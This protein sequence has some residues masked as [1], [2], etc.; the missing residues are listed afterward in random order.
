MKMK[1]TESN[2]TGVSL[3]KQVKEDY[4]AYSL[5]VIVGR[6]FPKY[7]D[8]CKSISRRILTAMKMLNLRPDG[9]YMKSARVEGEVMGKYSPHGSSYGSIVTLA[10]PW[11]NLVPLVDGHGNWGSSTDSPAQSRY[12]ECKLSSLAWDCLLDDSDTWE[13]IPNYDGSLQEPVELNVKFPYVLLNGQEGIG[14]GYACK[15]A[16]HSLRSIV[17]ATKLLCKEAPTDKAKA[18]NLRKARETLI[19]DFPTGTQVVKDEQLEQYTKTGAGS[20]RCMAK[21]EV[22]VQERAGKA[23]NR[24]TLTFTCLPPGTNPEKIGEQIKIELEKGRI[25]GIAEV[26]DLSDL[27]GDCIQIVVKLG[28]DLD[29]LKEELY[30]F[31]DLDSKFSAKTLVIDGVNPVEVSPVQVVKKW[32]AWRL[33]R[34]QVK[35]FKELAIKEDRLNIVQGLVKAIGKMDTIIKK[36]RAA[37]DRKEA[38]ASLMEPPLKFTENQADAILEMRLRQLT[39]LDQNELLSEEKLLNERI[40]E[41]KSLSEGSDVGVS[42][43]RSYMV[44]ELTEIGRKYGD[45]RRSPLIDCPK[46]TVSI[47]S[48]L[49]GVKSTANQKPRFMKIDQKKG[50]VEQSKGPRGAMVLEAKDKVVFMT[51]DGTLKKVGATFKGAISSSYSKVVLSKRESEVSSRMFLT[52]FELDGQIRAMVMNGEDLCRSTS[53]G[54]KWLPEGAKLIH[55][56]EGTAIIEWVSK[57]KKPLKVDLSTKIGK[58]GARGIKIADSKDVASF[59]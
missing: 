7:T 50:T 45:S 30:S 15:I 53:K 38:K 59:G 43:R 21:V 25:E 20:I 42:A 39:N 11:T 29:K 6:A 34:L 14:V 47:T 1:Q 54:K 24:P 18:E 57:R 51:E 36:I 3:T 2:Y 5:S 9:R 12:T 19:P 16:P 32:V 41:L 55:F 56:G 28:V 4:L 52:V 40:L 35:F 27:F 48:N 13:T 22:G 31:T 49:K 44:T 8:G 17:E 26:N 23:K 37:K 33:D 58:P 46:P 10:A